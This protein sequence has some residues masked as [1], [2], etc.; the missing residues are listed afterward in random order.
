MDEKYAGS[1]AF[2][3]IETN[4]G[5]QEYEIKDEYVRYILSGIAESDK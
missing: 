4:E 2:I 1:I 5:E 3:S